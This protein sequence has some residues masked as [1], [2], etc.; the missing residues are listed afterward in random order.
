MGGM[1]LAWKHERSF[2]AFENK[3]SNLTKKKR[4]GVTN[5]VCGLTYY[6]R[7]CYVHEKTEQINKKIEFFFYGWSENVFLHGKKEQI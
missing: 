6:K 2:V 5:K 1:G 4:K 3:N 7:K